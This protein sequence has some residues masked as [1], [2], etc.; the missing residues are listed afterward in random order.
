[1]AAMKLIY[2]ALIVIIL[3]AILVWLYYSNSQKAPSVPSRLNFTIGVCT[4]GN[5]SSEVYALKNGVK[6]FRTDIMLSASQEELLSMENSD[7]GA[8]YLGILDYSTLP[9]GIADKNWSLGEW[10]ESVADAVEMYPWI[11]TWEIWNEPLVPQFQT[12]YMNGSA[13]NYYMV[14]KSAATV[15][16]A[17]EPNATIVCFGGAP[18]DNYPAY[19]WYAQV[20]SY[21][22]WKYCNAISLHIYPDG[23]FLPG[24]SLLEEWR[25]SIYSYENLT[26]EP[27]WITEFGMPSS[28]EVI[29]GYT[30]RLQ[31]EFLAQQLSFFNGIS[32]VKRVYWYDLWGLSDGAL[33][34]NFGLLNLT[35]PTSA[36]SSPAWRLLDSIANGSTTKT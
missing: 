4:H 21:G 30:P 26:N 8:Q 31:E 5:E 17:H 10:N 2:I 13:Y 7:Y 19:E 36:Y 23:P 24:N 33:G 3:A 15:I 29:Y 25:S 20:W 27:I 32:F 35:N 16:R 11:S 18:I 12:G 9:G 22:A 14:I 34:N 28:S 6:N 1:M